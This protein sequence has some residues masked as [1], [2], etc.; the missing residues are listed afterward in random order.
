MKK[1]NVL[2][3]GVSK[4]TK[5]GMWTVVNNYLNSNDYH[6]NIKIKYISTATIGKPIYRLI[7]S[8]IGVLR[9]FIQ[10]IFKRPQ[11]VHIHM[12]EKGSVWRKGAIVNLCY[13]LKVPVIIHLHGADFQIWYENISEK[14]KIRV[15][16]ILNKGS[17][18]LILGNYWRS[19]IETIIEE[20][21]K[22]VVLYNSV[23][24]QPYLYSDKS[25]DI[26][27]LG[28]VIERKGIIDLIDAIDLIRNKIPQ[29]W[30]LRIFGPT[31]NL[32]IEKI[33][34][35]KNLHEYI[36][37]EGFIEA[38]TIKDILSE[39][40]F[41]V[42]PSYNE[43]LPMTILETMSFGIPSIATAVA[44]VPELVMHNANGVLQNPGDVETLGNNLLLMMQNTELR[45]RFS[46]ESY[47][48]IN[49]K[50]LLNTHVQKLLE[51]YKQVLD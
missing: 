10:I 3:I 42:L 37:Y 41:N 4:K 1:I 27:F 49:E 13:F 47:K 5:G 48:T 29:K 44:A 14:S 24:E 32:D 7:Y 46:K 2:M 8:V 23:E 39:V 25:T 16:K 9:S 45:S 50:F 15:E 6:N 18:I 33:I 19:F 43:G 12:S 31:F 36:N 30:R 17:K 11:L 51:I 38:E 28:A 21:N 34:N 35:D 26:I 40:A 20:R 22:I